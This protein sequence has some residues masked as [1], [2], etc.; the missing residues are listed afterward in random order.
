MTEF[1]KIPEVEHFAVIS[2]KTTSVYHE[3]DERSRT[4]PGHGY[5]AYTSTITSIEY[6]VFKSEADLIDWLKW[7]QNGAKK[8]R[9]IKV[10]PMT[11]EL[12]LSIKVK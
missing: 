11:V 4:H 2:E 10:T 1:S 5:P 12:N 8:F 6:E 3:G 9:V 7:N